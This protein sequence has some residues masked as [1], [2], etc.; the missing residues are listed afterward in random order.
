MATPPQLHNISKYK[1][2]HNWVNLSTNKLQF[3]FLM[4]KTE[5]QLLLWAL[6]IAPNKF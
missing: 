3:V 4:V 1:N 2:L 5:W 6:T